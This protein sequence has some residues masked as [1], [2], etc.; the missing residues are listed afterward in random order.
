M[1]TTTSGATATA[2]PPSIPSAAQLHTGQLEDYELMLTAMGDINLHNS[3]PI[4]PFSPL[5]RVSEDGFSAMWQLLRDQDFM[6]LCTNLELQLL[7]L[8]VSLEDGKYIYQ[9]WGIDGNRVTLPLTEHA[10]WQALKP[11]IEMAA[12]SLGGAIN[13]NRTISMERICWFYGLAPWIRQNVHEHAAA[14]FALQENIAS[15]HLKLEDDFDILELRRRPTDEDRAAFRASRR[16]SPNPSQ[17]DT[18]TVHADIIRAEIIETVNQFLPEG[19]TSPLTY[20]ANDILAG[21]T[22]EQVRATPTIYLQKILQSAKAETLGMLLLSAMDWYGGEIGEETSPYIRT[23]L[24]ANALQLWLASRTSENPDQIAGYA[25]QARAN[26]GKSYQ[27]IRAEFEAHLLTSKQASSEKEA[28]VIARL[29]LP[30]FPAEFRARGIPVDLAYRSTVVWV[31]FVNGV[32]I[33]NATDPGLLGR[34]RF[35]QLVNLPIQLSEGAT[36]EQLSQIGLARLLPTLDWAVAQGVIAQKSR[37]DYTQDDIDRAL[38][39]LDKQTNELNEAIVRIDEE[40][41]QR[42]SMAKNE[43]ERLFGKVAFTSDGRKLARTQM[44]PI[45]YSRD[46][47]FLRGKGYDSYSLLDVLASGKFDDQKKWF[48]TEADGT[49]LSSKWIQIDESRTIKSNGISLGEGWG[50]RQKVL[51]PFAK[52]LD[53]KT[54]FDNDFKHHLERITAAYETLIKSLLASLPY[55]DRQALEFGEIKVHSLRMQTNLV[56]ADN[57]TPEII[58]PLRAR[59]GLILQATYEHQTTC[60]ELLPR[61]GMLRRIENLDSK[62]FG[63][64]LKSEKWRVSKNGTSTVKVL[65]HKTVPFDWDA[66]LNGTAPKK[67]TDCQ[68]IIEQLGDTLTATPKP[69]QNTQGAPLTLSS[70]R[71]AA[72]SHHIATALLFVDPVAL[73]KSAY[74]Q[75]Q[76]ELEDE[77]TETGLAII[78][79]VVPFWGSIEDLMSGDKNRYPMGAFGLFTDLLSF[80]LPFGKF[81][82]GSVRV[83]TTTA[84]LSLRATLPAFTSLTKKL[85]ISTLSAL[86]PLDGIPSLLKV[87]GTTA[88]KGGR[89]ALGKLKGLAGRTGHYDFVHSLPQTGEAERWRPLADGDQLARVRGVDDVPVRNLTSSGKSDYRLIDPLSSKP[90]GPTLPTRAGELSQGRSHYA[91]LKKTNNQTLVDL[92]ENTSVREVLEIDGRTTLFL[93]DVPYR[94]DGDVLR[95]V[96]LIDDSEALK[97]V[98]CRPRRMPGSDACI[99]SYVTGDPAPTPALGSFDETKGY[100]PWF[101]DRLS[102]PATRPGHEG[103]FFARDGV[104]YKDVDNVLTAHKEH[105]TTLGFAKDWLVPGKEISTNLQF[106]KGIYGRIEVR[107]AYEGTDDLHR[108][109]AI[110]VPSIDETKTHVFTR[111]NTDKYYHTTVLAGQ[112]LTEPLT[113]KRLL[114]AELAEG[115]EGAELLRV[116]TGSL[117]ANNVARIYGVDAIERAMETME[118]IAIRIGTSA[119]PP[120][121]MKWLKVDTSPG[122]ALMFDHSTR[123]IVTQLPKG[124]TS[125]SRSKVAPE[126]FRQRTVE[127]FDTLFLEPSIVLKNTDSALRIDSTMKKLHNLIPRHQ[128]PFNARN[129][130][131]AEV[132][133]ATGKREVYVSVS[134]AQGATGHLPLFRHNLGADQVKVGETTY[135]NVD[136]NEVFPSTSLRVSD[137]GKLLAVPA[138]IK[139]IESYSPILTRKP[140]SLDSESKLISVIREK[141]P[142][143]RSIGTVNV[144]TTMPPCESCSV[145]IKEFGYDGR[146]NALNVLWH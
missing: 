117:G 33:V 8:Y 30:L 60:Y 45:L 120:T 75:T 84:R 15:H 16:R 124:A 40:A 102:T 73:R 3:I 94:L 90:Y 66:H 89:F 34:L 88:W 43:L 61:V 65:R 82:S 86:N 139:D 11:R 54:L 81:V 14:K 68:A 126:A 31:N 58:L 97:L 111:L 132:V 76:F 56:E 121:N 129:I 21:A 39:E 1:Q 134:G 67:Q 119:T 20:L 50:G 17:V 115:T 19:S 48:V 136:M 41:P 137:E 127:I 114:K 125:W 27:A 118:R 112:S 122:E 46:T 44:E 22:V 80:G 107:G 105:F 103:A 131:Y 92:S 135:F 79:M 10:K 9:T 130:A 29:F 28:I 141:Y 113:L 57:E 74:G 7:D 12:T 110:L 140:T 53:V 62:L 108:V 93:D 104:V 63:G 138:T 47:P 42:L 71:S 91:P 26:W 85:L 49:T 123:M 37:K 18:Q 32:N 23:K 99:N 59:N 77:Q 5:H 87:L 128:R 95:R 100:A 64:E 4:R 36:Q 38:S 133:T 70:S 24:I 106:R 144:A 143:P 52:L 78:K 25:L 142:D 51:S 116:Y 146:E 13:S 109:G 6:D 101:G 83:I 98:P 55:T 72:I 96:D 2:L 69:A 145:V 35:E